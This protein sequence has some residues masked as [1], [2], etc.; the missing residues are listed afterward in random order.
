MWRRINQWWVWG[1][2]YL[3][4]IPLFALRYQHLPR[5]F[6][7]ATA[8]FEP[9]LQSRP[10]I[11]AESL[12]V[13]AVHGFM[14]RHPDGL[15]HVDGWTVFGRTLRVLGVRRTT[16]ENAPLYMSTPDESYAR[17]VL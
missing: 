15:A 6:Y 17:F 16:I 3:A 2:L 13:E 12:T 7:H 4:A 5:P 14:D 8:R 10:L 11:L 1:L 9:E